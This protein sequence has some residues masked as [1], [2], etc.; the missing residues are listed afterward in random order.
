MVI[1]FKKSFLKS[2]EV[3]AFV[4]ESRLN[5]FKEKIFEHLERIEREEK[6]RLK[7]V[8]KALFTMESLG[9]AGFPVGTIREWKGKKYIKT[10]PGKWRRKYEADSRGAKLSIAAIK[11]KVDAC[12][13]VGELLQLS[14]IHI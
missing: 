9:K 4:K 11:R 10:A 13:T 8:K 2:A 3:K 5:Y 14:L 12:A 7:E 6:K 1:V